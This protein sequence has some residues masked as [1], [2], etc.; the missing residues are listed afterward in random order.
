MVKWVILAQE[1]ADSIPTIKQI[2]QILT[3][4]F[5]CV[6][7]EQF[8]NLVWMNNIITEL[9]KIENLTRAHTSVYLFIIRDKKYQ[10]N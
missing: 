8:K 3:F 6:Y 1:V 4:L 7:S 10:P 5:D 2:L 9:M